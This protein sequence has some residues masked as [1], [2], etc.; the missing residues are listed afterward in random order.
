VQQVGLLRT[1]RQ[2]MAAGAISDTDRLF[3]EVMLSIN[4]IASGLRTTG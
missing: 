3:A 2:A 1:W 4:A